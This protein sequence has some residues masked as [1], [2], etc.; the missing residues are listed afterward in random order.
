M[1]VYNTNDILINSTNIQII[2]LQY[3]LWRSVTGKINYSFQVAAESDLQ[4]NL[5]EVHLHATSS[6]VL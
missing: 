5:V 2:F 6:N 4:I 3:C 1:L